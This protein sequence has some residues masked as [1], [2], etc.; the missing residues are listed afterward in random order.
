MR[1]LTGGAGQ[2]RLLLFLNWQ[3]G[4]KTLQREK[5]YISQPIPIATA[6]KA[7]KAHTA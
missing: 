6:K 5:G 1:L 2:V 3:S 4:E 7:R